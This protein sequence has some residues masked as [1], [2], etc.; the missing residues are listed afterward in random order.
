[1]AA[2][3]AAGA[4]LR[5]STLD[6]QSFWDDE[7]VTVGTVLAP[8]LWS[9][10]GHI[11]SSEAS[12]PLYYVLAWL[13]TK[14]FGHGE[15]GIRSLSAVL[16][17]AT[18]PVVWWAG[19]TL[20][21][22][23]VGL[24]AAAL[25]AASPEMVWYSQ[26]ARGYALLVLLC[27]I[28]LGCMAEV[29]RSG[30]RRMLAGWAIASGLAIAT[31]Y[32]G[33][34]VAI[35]EAIALL[36]LVPELRRRVLVA[37]A[38]VGAVGAALLPLAIHQ[39]GYGHD[40]WIKYL[41]LSQRLGQLWKEFAIGRAGTPPDHLLAIG[42]IATIATAA[43]A[44]WGGVQRERRRGFGLALGIG[45]GALV[46]PLAL[47]LV[48]E[49]YFYARNLIGAWV[50]LAVAVAVA[51]SVRWIGALAIAALCGVFLAINIVIDSD[52]KIQRADWRAVAHAIGPAPRLRAIVAPK[53][54]RHAIVYYLGRTRE[55]P[56]GSLAVSEI[57]LLGRSRAH[58]PRFGPMP[59]GFRRI[60]RRRVARFTFIRYVAQGRHR[61]TVDQLRNARLDETRAAI[62]IER[63]R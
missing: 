1:M 41:P 11:P 19:R 17:T 22:R 4:A 52:P 53:D 63:P 21:S 60:S 43:L 14:V 62:L 31:H 49:D 7:A 47:K 42:H 5:F 46:L 38:A 8:S 25:V 34:F 24:A 39:A 45:A 32:F 35:P 12:P 33:A 61:L 20:V 6:L 15:V 3:V 59:S 56:E 2:I 9:T 57:D 29:L 55:I 58:G 10:L 40:V 26:E 30:S 37:T 16:G 48:N 27:A 36:W 54:G 23:P 44:V 13:W 18:I 51:A 50:A 28:S